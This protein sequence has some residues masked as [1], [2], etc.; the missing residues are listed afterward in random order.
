MEAEIGVMQPQTKGCWQSPKAERSK[1]LSLPV[2]RRKQPYQH[3]DSHQV[4]LIL[5]FRLQDF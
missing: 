4:K 3:F 5:D 2:S 1:E